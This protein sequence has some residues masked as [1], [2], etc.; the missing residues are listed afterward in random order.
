VYPVIAEPLA[1]DADHEI[2]AVDVSANVVMPVIDGAPG[3]P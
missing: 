1:A 2:V 3:N